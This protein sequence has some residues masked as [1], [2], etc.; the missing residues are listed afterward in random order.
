MAISIA[1]RLFY[2]YAEEQ[3]Q[4]AA[5][6]LYT[7]GLFQGVGTLSDGTPDFD[8]DREPTRAEAVTMLVRLLG[9]E[10]TAQA[11]TYE[12]PFTDVPSWAEPYVGYAYANGLTN[13]ISESEFGSGAVVTAAQYLTF[14]L[15]ALGYSDITDFEW[16]SAWTL[17]DKLGI[18]DG[19]YGAERGS[20]LRGGVVSVSFAAL[21]ASDKTTGKPLFESL[22]DSGAITEANAV[23]VGLAKPSAAA[24]VSA[25]PVP[26]A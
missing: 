25:S 6:K 13:G 2:V 10:Q 15:R 21:S 16:S 18:T 22:I 12:L 9:K 11:G 24:A 14:I 3:A 4:I 8:L 7:L 20:I 23:R 5:D 17:T 26:S 19:E 1:P